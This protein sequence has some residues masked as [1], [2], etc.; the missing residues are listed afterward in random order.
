MAQKTHNYVTASIDAQ[1]EFSA[2][3]ET[4]TQVVGGTKGIKIKG[5]F[6]VHIAG[7]FVATLH[8]QRSW[9]E[10]AT[11]YD[12]KS[13]DAPTDPDENGFEPG[14]ALYRIGCKTGN[15]TSGTATILIQ[16]SS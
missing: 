9:N 5:D 10:G 14:G 15:F 4:A 16:G 1:N 3:R 8:L 7:T 12:V 13:Y 6:T 11:W 2:D